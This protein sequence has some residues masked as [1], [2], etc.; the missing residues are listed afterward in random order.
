VS[1]CSLDS[2]SST[3][4]DP[5]YI[6]T[7]TME[8]MFRRKDTKNDRCDAKTARYQARFR[9]ILGPSPSEDEY[10]F[11]GRNPTPSFLSSTGTTIPGGL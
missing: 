3:A 8:N 7:I 1:F 10:Y 4:N 5:G 11:G 2:L 6:D 9:S